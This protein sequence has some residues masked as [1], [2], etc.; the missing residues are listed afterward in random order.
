MEPF[1]AFVM[2]AASLLH[3]SWH[4]LVKSSGDR[5]VA[6]AG[7]NVVSATAA[8]VALPFAGAIPAAAAAV[9]AGSVLLHFGYKL[10]LAR[11]Y[12]AADLGQAYPLARGVTPLAACAIAFLALGERPS[13]AGFAGLLL[14]SAGLLA[15]ALEGG[16]RRA[17]VATLAAALCAGAAVAGYS[18]VDAYGVR[19]TGDWFA[20]TAWLG[21]ADSSAFVLYALATRRYASLEAWG[22]GWHRVLATGTLGLASF[23]VFMW[24][25]GRA[26]VALVA[27]LRETSVLFAALIGIAFLGERASAARLGAAVAVGAGVAMIA[28]SRPA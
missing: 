9:I 23:C 28:L 13:G 5:V 14:V 19:L 15:L 18:V 3:A 21:A 26:P 22:R 7:M 12:E 10:A 8:W 24:A 17:R 11:L 20:F 16:T 4:A 27:A 2:L 6:L 1:V 25:L